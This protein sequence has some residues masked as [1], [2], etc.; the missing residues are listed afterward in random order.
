[1]P[2]KY[3]FFLKSFRSPLCQATSVGLW[4]VLTTMKGSPFSACSS[5]TTSG[6]SPSKP[7]LSTGRPS[8]HWRISTW[9]HPGA[10]TSFSSTSYPSTCSPSWFVVASTIAFTWL[11]QPST[12]WE[13]SFLCRSHSL[14]FN[15]YKHQNTWWWVW[16]KAGPDCRG[17]IFQNQSKNV[18][19]IN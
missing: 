5:P 6:S 4:L 12:P 8:A 15:P 17:G 16:V 3:P 7:A 18:P 9:S 19:E 14:D 10:D 11:T 2:V 1:M 13:Q